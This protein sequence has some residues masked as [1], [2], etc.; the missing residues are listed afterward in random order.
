M[1]SAELGASSEGY[2][3]NRYNRSACSRFVTHLDYSGTTGGDSTNKGAEV[4][5]PRVVLDARQR[6]SRR[7]D[8]AYPWSD[9]LDVHEHGFDKRKKM[10]RGKDVP[11]QPPLAA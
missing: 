2:T 6:V 4:T 7:S 9:D 3:M 1:S 10:T 11:E 8:N 5:V